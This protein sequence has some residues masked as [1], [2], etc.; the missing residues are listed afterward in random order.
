MI[1]ALPALLAVS[2][3]VL[4]FNLESA[5]HARIAIRQLAVER[6][7]LNARLLAAERAN[8]AADQPVDDPAPDAFA[9]LVADPGYP[10]SEGSGPSLQPATCIRSWPPI[11]RCTHWE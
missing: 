6:A 9:S 10:Y 2:A 1:K 7:A 11:Q 5:R 4:W 3:G 8:A